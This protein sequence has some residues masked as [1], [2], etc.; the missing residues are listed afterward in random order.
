MLTIPADASAETAMQ[1]FVRSGYARIPVIGENVDDLCGILYV[2]DVMRAIHSPW[3]PRPQRPVHEILRPARFAPECVAAASAL[4][5]M[6]SS[7]VQ[8]SVVLYEYGGAAGIVSIKAMLEAVVGDVVDEH[9]RHEPERQDLGGGRYRV[10]ARA[11][12]SEVGDLFGLELDDDDIDSVGGLLA[13]AT[14]RVPIPGT[15]VNVLGLELEA[16]KSAGRRKRLS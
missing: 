3:D 15:Q 2:K 1:L 4:A 16:E 6:Q 5:Q 12:L 11:G 8:I 9:D 13:K 10:P 14:G 7:P